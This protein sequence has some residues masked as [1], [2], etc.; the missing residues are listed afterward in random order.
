MSKTRALDKILGHLRDGNAIILCGAGVSKGPPSNLPLWSEIRSHLIQSLFSGS[1]ITAHYSHYSKRLS[2][3]MELVLQIIYEEVSEYVFS[4]LNLLNIT[5]YNNNHWI[6]AQ[7]L[8]QGCVRQVIT[9]NFDPLIETA[10]SDTGVKFCRRLGEGRRETGTSKVPEVFKIHGTVEVPESVAALLHQV[11]SLPRAKAR[12]LQRAIESSFLLVIGYSGNDFDIYPTFFNVR[13]FAIAW[14][15][16][17]SERAPHLKR[18]KEKSGS[19]IQIL[20]CDLNRLL[21][22]IASE[23]QLRRQNFRKPACDPTSKWQRMIL[24][25]TGNLDTCDRLSIVGRLLRYGGYTS[26]AIDC[27]RNALT[28]A[29]RE[30]DYYRQY[31]ALGYCAELAEFTGNIDSAAKY[32]AH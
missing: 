15:L 17:P 7:L 11:G 29:R 12:L 23:L 10:L 28:Q 13:P 21:K 24:H 27:F 1:R 5:K 25:W 22:Q 9:T 14:V 30:K 4:L 20:R 18:L 26:A 16:K 31:D 19:K 6:I 8:A 32:V 2:L 3:P